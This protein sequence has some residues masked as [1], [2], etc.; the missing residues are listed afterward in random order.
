MQT[1]FCCVFGLWW[2]RFNQIYSKSLSWMKR[3]PPHNGISKAHV[4]EE[5]YYCWCCNIY[6]LFKFLLCLNNICILLFVVVFV[7]F[8][9]SLCRLLFT[10]VFYGPC[11]ELCEGPRLRSK[12]N[13][14]NMRIARSQ[15]TT[16]NSAK[17][18]KFLQIWDRKQILSA[19]R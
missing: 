3:N 5:H 2:T 18:P 7:I 14:N 10:T 9:L 4:N 8:F 16:N 17:H 12:T 11:C 15:I 19:S 1:H 13:H 6:S